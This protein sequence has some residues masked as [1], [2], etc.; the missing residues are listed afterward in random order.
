MFS[1]HSLELV[2]L[3]VLF[4]I[5]SLSGYISLKT[6]ALAKDSVVARMAKLVEEAHNKKSKT[7]RFV[8]NCAKYYIPG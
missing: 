6:T 7:Q 3:L 4:V 5:I 2:F 1:A 8:D